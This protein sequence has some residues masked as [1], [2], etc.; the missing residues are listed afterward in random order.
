M[1]IYF[2]APLFSDAELEYNREVADLFEDAGHSVFL[3]QRDG[4]EGM[5]EVFELDGVETP[6]DAMVEIFKL[7]REEVL[8]ADVVTAVLDGQVPDEGVAVEMG[9]AHEHDIP[10]IGLKTDRRTFAQDEELN[11]MLIGILEEIVK[12]PE[13][14]LEAVEAYAES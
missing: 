4:Y 9:M 5:D 7:D 8:A 14:L 3:P 2:A 13:A 6:H 10:V 11:A 1:R 12:T